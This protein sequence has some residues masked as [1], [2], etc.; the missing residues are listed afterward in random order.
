VRFGPR[1][2]QRTNETDD[3][4][5]A[6][7]ATFRWRFASIRMRKVAETYGPVDTASD[8][9]VS[10]QLLL[11][12]QDRS[13]FADGYGRK[14]ILE[15]TEDQRRVF[16]HLVLRAWAQGITEYLPQPD[17]AEHGRDVQEARLAKDAEL[18][19]NARKVLSSPS[20]QL[21]RRSC[22]Y[23]RRC[24]RHEQPDEEPN[25]RCRSISEP[26]HRSASSSSPPNDG[27]LIAQP[28]HPPDHRNIDLELYRNI[29]TEL[30]G[31][32]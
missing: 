23:A 22:P 6:S 1:L 2:D 27:A 10:L 19:P 8:T 5:P 21:P 26:G 9:A 4:L 24:S 16:L 20:N 30:S 31:Y 28:C 25:Q 32:H 13:L 14:N 18:P 12:E 11:A 29:D 15:Q 7:D 17:S 3:K